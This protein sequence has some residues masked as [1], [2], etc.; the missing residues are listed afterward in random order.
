MGLHEFVCVIEPINAMSYN[1]FYCTEHS[2]SVYIY[3]DECIQQ[4]LHPHCAG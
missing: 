4:W 2:Y 3:P 1:S